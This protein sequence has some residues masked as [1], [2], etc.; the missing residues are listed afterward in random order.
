MTPF[1]ITGFLRS[2]TTLLEKY[3]HNHPQAVVASQPFPYL[4]YTVKDAFYRRLGVDV[5]RYPLGNLFGERLYLR[6]QFA[7]FLVQYR[8]SSAE[9]QS[10]M[11]RMR[12]YSGQMTPALLDE[13]APGGKFIDVFREYSARYPQLLAKPGVRCA[14]SKEVF[15][16]EFIPYFLREGV[17]VALIIRDPRAVVASIHGGRG[18]NY[19]N[20]G[21][22]VLH[23]L[24]SW[25]KSVAFAIHHAGH[26]QFHWMRHEQLSLS[27]G[28]TLAPLARALG[29]ARFPDAV[30]Q[31]ELVS[32][33][34]SRW[35]GNSSFGAP[36]AG[37]PRYRQ[38][39]DAQTIAFIDTVCGPEMAWL[40]IAGELPATA[41]AIDAFR[42]PFQPG[43]PAL[44]E[45]DRQAELA[46]LDMIANGHAGNSGA[47][48]AESWFV[49]SSV[50][51]ALHRASQ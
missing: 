46:R 45:Q 51:P 40:G 43:C 26:P 7:D 12:G 5:P 36:E 37:V 35:Q 28:D 1:F 9:V 24:R 18:A 23:I 41:Q 15:C 4:F 47:A 38:Y 8:M 48:E 13:P 2:G 16:E 14:G 44:A 11:E 10:V 22:S 29:L 6:E 19:A 30:L 39:L 50:R 17:P 25:R 42:D 34:G 31:G 27:P 20:A 49:F 32:Q 21:L 33:D 3:L